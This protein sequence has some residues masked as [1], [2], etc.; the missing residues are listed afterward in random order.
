MKHV[1]IEFMQRFEMTPEKAE[2]LVKES[3]I[4]ACSNQ[5]FHTF[6]NENDK[7]YHM[8]D[9]LSIMELQELVK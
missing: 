6:Q 2:Q 4:F 8:R 3:K 7:V 9:V 5:E 1:I